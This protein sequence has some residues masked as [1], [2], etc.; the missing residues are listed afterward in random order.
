MTSSRPAREWFHAFDDSL[1]ELVRTGKISED[2]LR[3]YAPKAIRQ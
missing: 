3:Q 2:T 1:H